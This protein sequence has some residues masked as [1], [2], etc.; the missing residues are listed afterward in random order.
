MLQNFFFNLRPATIFNNLDINLAKSRQGTLI[1]TFS[2]ELD[3]KLKAELLTR[4][5]N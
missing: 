1:Y 4:K 2:K 3:F 5:K